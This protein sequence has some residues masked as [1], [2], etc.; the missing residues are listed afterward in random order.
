M[1]EEKKFSDFQTYKC[2]IID[3]TELD[4][5]VPKFCPSCVKDPSFVNPIWYGTS[6]PW[7]DKKN[8]LYKVNVTAII[9]DLNLDLESTELSTYS[10]TYGNHQE[11]DRDYLNSDVVQSQIMRTAIYQL[12]INY[13]KEIKFKHICNTNDCSVIKSKPL[14]EE[15]QAR[16]EEVID[17]LKVLKKSIIEDLTGGEAVVFE[18]DDIN[19]YFEYTIQL[20]ED[21]Q[22]SNTLQTVLERYDELLNEREQILRKTRVDITKFNPYG[23]E[24]FS[25]IEDVYYPAAPTAGTTIQFLVS[26]PAFVLDRIPSASQAGDD[27]DDEGRDDFVIKAPNLRRQLRVLSSAMWLYTQQYAVSRILDGTAMYY[28]GTGL[29]EYDFELVR[30]NLKTFPGDGKIDFNN[31]GSDVFFKLL[32]DALSANNFRIDNFQLGAMFNKRAKN[33]KFKVNSEA[34]KPFQIKNIFVETKECRYKKLKGGAAH[35]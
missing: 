11:P 20:D 27:E 23:L 31:T 10:I 16:L 18:Q 12:L 21:E 26:V 7:L 17:Y 14:R 30:K 28:E 9:K 34:D 2:D 19:S 25:V 35:D 1:S 15:D 33:I 29:K 24:N 3:L 22:L 6:E 4:I 5:E 32:K 8:C 13:D